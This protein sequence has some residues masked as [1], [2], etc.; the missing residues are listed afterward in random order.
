MAKR[1]SRWNLKNSKGWHKRQ[2]ARRRTPRF[3]AL[4]RRDML[5]VETVYLSAS[6]LEA[7][8]ADEGNVPLPVILALNQG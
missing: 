3:D 7:H 4:E 6:D 5:T 8:E 2:R 1:W